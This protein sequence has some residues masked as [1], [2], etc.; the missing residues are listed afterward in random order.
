M[1]V[2]SN[3]RWGA[4]GFGQEYR[5]GRGGPCSHL[6]P[7][8]SYWCQPDG[9]VAATVYMVRTPSGIAN[10]TKQ[11]P[12]SPYKGGGANATVFYWRPGHWFTIMYELAGPITDAGDLHFGRGGYQGAEGHDTVAGTFVFVFVFLCLE[13]P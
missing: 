11:L 7:A 8:E 5:V 9:R 6:T 4:H 2:P 13:K 1:P 10:T 12:H 3:D